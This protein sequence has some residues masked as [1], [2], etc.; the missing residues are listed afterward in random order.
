M[1]R[2]VIGTLVD[3]GAASEE[4]ADVLTEYASYLVQTR[5][6]PEAYN[7]YIKLAPLYEAHYPHHSPKYL[8]FSSGFL[9][10][11]S[12]AGYFSAV[13]AVYK[14][15]N[16]N[17][18][19]VDVVAPSVRTQL[20]FQNIYQISRTPSQEG[21]LPNA[22]VIKRIALV[23]PNFLKSWRNRI[24]FSYFAL[25][26]GDVDLAAQFNSDPPPNEPPDQQLAS[27]EVILKSFIA[28]RSNNFEDSI[29]L[30]REAVDKILLFHQ[31]FENETSERLPTITAEERLVLSRILGINSPHI[32]NFDQA[33]SMFILAQF[34][35]RYKVKLG[36]NERAIRQELKSD[37]KREDIRTRD[38]LKDV[39]DRAMHEAADSLFARVLPVRSHTQVEHDF[40]YLL[41]LEDIEDKIASAND[42]LP[43]DVLKSPRGSADSPIDLRT[44]QGLIKSDE[45]LVLHVFVGG[46][47]VTACIDLSRS[48]FNVQTLD[49]PAI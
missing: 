27:Y 43:N 10:A 28:A 24:I 23:D 26:A 8:H 32:S 5:Q 7:L 6:L 30:S 36:L 39:R 42:Q 46:V 35:N 22:E 33:N 49:G 14:Q 44:I 9:A 3:K 47:L 4:I 13:D 17:V 25:L 12:D 45:A 20:F 19:T 18:A 34:L 15:L 37:L 16:E 31:R 29:A 48:T 2:A 41:R 40:G 21:Y 38:R 1:R 11:L